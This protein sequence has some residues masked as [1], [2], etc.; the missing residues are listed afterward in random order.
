MSSF[1]ASC[2][3]PL[4]LAAPGLVVQDTPPGR[5]SLVKTGFLGPG[6]EMGLAAKDFLLDM[7]LVRE[8]LNLTA[9]QLSRIARL[10]A[11]NDPIQKILTQQRQQQMREL[12]KQGNLQ[13][14][15][16]MRAEGFR[17]AFMMTRE[18]DAPLVEVLDKKQRDRLEQ[19]QLQGDG[20]MAF[21]R[22]EVQERLAIPP[23]QFEAIKEVYE[24]GSRAFEQAATVPADVLP[25]AKGLARER[26]TALME[27]K[28][29]KT[30]V[31]KGR[32]AVVKTRQDTMREIGKVLTKYQRAQ[33]NRMLGPPFDFTKK[34]GAKESGDDKRK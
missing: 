34:P 33:F 26:R 27:T 10:R 14:E 31:E 3:I 29:V 20:P 1:F 25:E 7:P 12:R 18:S 24:R 4:V 8:E 21:L 30:E 2:L 32:Q 28:A 15:A 6:V 13:A 23:E 9:D 19:I 5:T 17:S 16:L 11:L 22:P